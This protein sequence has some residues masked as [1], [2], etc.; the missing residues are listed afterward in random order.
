MMKADHKFYK[1]H[2]GCD[3]T[4]KKKGT[5]MFMYLV[6]A[7]LSNKKIKAKPGSNL[8]ESM[9]MPYKK[10]PDEPDNKNKG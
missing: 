5:I 6:G 1:E 10:V 3:F 4:Q 8:N 7:M 9:L 2:G